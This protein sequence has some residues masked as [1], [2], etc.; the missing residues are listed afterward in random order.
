[1]WKCE[2]VINVEMK[3]WNDGAIS[4]FNILINHQ[5]LTYG[6]EKYYCRKIIGFFS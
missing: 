5:T 3:M 6:A 4:I 2:D 1:M